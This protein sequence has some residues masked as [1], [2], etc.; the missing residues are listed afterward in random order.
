MVFGRK[1]DPKPVDAAAA[2]RAVDDPFAGPRSGGGAAEAA[3][4]RA[5]AEAD[6]I[7]SVIGSDLAIEGQS[8][9]IRCNGRLRVNGNI[10]ADL[11]GRQLVVGEAA[12]ITGAIAAEAVDVHGKVQGTIEAASVTLRATADVEGDI[13]SGRLA[14]EPG[15]QFDGRAR[16]LGAAK[17]TAAP[18]PAVLPEP[19]PVPLFQASG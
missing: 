9:T 13:T 1:P 5:A 12:T 10:Q 6:M 11:H 17:G 16:K 14:I 19:R 3:Q 7:E 2:A 4:A 8:I 18:S 15:A